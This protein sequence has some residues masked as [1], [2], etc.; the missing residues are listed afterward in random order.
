VPPATYLEE[1]VAAHRAMAA[2]DPRDLD[3]LVAEAEATPVPRGFVA[4]LAPSGAGRGLAVVAEIKRR[5]PSKG[6]LAPDLDP[7][8][9]ARDYADGGAAALSVLTDQGYFGARRSDLAD[10]RSACALPV[11]RKDFTVSEL[12]VCDARL[13][14]ADAVLLIVAALSDDE[15]SRFAGLARHLSLDAVV[16]VHDEAELDRALGSGATV[17]GVNQRDLTTFEVDPDRAVRVV[18]AIP[19]GVVAVAE[20]GIRGAADARRLA[21]AGF[22]AVLVGETV[23]TAPDRRAAVAELAGHPVGA[24]TAGSARTAGATGATEPARTA[25][26]G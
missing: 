3:V 16:E 8:A 14:G 9:V 5:S 18:G 19:G 26:G 12:D 15:L 6:D 11:L 23:V 7:A 25:G 21:D 17:I 1:I 22:D 24:R 20:S 10:A 2:G 13:M 4:A